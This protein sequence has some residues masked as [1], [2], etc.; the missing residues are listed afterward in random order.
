MVWWQ[1]DMSE[2]R[3]KAINK[4]RLNDVMI[5]AQLFDIYGSVLR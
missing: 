2:E 3:E 4:H 5:M 1:L